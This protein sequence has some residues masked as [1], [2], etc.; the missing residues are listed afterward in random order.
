MIAHSFCRASVQ[1]AIEGGMIVYIIPGK[2]ITRLSN[3][4]TNTLPLSTAPIALCPLKRESKE[5]LHLCDAHSN[6]TAK[7]MAVFHLISSLSRSTLRPLLMLTGI[8]PKRENFSVSI[9][10]KRMIEVNWY[11]N[12]AFAQWI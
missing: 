5:T 3:F 12:P 10:L 11:A 9:E 4:L 6:N 2:E 1:R 7:I 8:F